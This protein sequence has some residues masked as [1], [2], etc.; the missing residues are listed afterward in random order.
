MKKF[1]LDWNVMKNWPPVL[2][3]VFA[4]LVGIIGFIVYILIKMYVEVGILK[5]YCAALATFLIWFVHKAK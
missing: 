5:Y 2:W 4:G 1:T 3:G